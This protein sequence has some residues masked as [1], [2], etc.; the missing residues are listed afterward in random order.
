MKKRIYGWIL[1]L[2]I[3]ITTCFANCGSLITVYGETEEKGTVTVYFTLSEDGKFVTGNDDNETVLCHIPVTI[4]YFD[5]AEYGMEDYYRYEADS[6]EEGGRYNS[7]KIVERP[8]LLHLFIKMLEKYYLGNGEKFVVNDRLQ[9]AMSISGSATSL[10][11]TRFWGHDENLMYYVDHEYPLQAAGWGS[12]SDYILLEDGMEI[13]VAMF[14]DWDFYHTGAFSFFTSEST[15]CTNPGIFDIHTNENITLTMR[16]TATNAANDGNSSFVGEAMPG[17]KV[18]YCN[19]LQAVSDYNNDNWKELSQETDDNGQITLTFDKP[20]TYYVSSTSTYENYKL[21]SGNACVAP[22]IAVINVSGENVSEETT[23]NHPGE[24][25]GRL[26][27]NIEISNGISDN[28]KSY[29]FDAPFDANTKEY[30]ITVPDYED[31]VCVKVG[32]EESVPDGTEIKANY[33]DTNGESKEIIISG[34]DELGKKLGKII[35]KGTVDNKFVLTAAYSKV[36][37]KY[38]FNIKRQ[39]T[40]KGITFANKKTGRNISIQPEFNRDTYEYEISIPKNLEKIETQIVPYDENYNIYVNDEP[41][42]GNSKIDIST[43][44]DG[45]KI[46]AKKMSAVIRL[47]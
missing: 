43:E 47:T 12:T 37:E 46:S 14:S 8:T 35:E 2:I 24:Y 40:L 23:E 33:T 6:F 32:L 21:S 26:I 13:D 11:M 20:G 41:V 42:D 31:S 4:S 22:P 7:D 28:S 29:K 1:S 34:N 25:D 44:I 15:K 27:K 16:G 18:V 5:L 45:I 38:T 19:A 10:Y 17:E 39:T 3:V 30:T 36:V 9:D